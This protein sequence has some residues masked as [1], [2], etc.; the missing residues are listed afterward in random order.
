M[1][2][3]ND[4]EAVDLLLRKGFT[5]LETH[6]LILLRRTYRASELDEAPLD[7]ARLEFA[8]WLVMTGRLTDQIAE[9]KVS[10]APPPEK[11]PIPKTV[12]TGLKRH[13]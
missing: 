5:A 11:T 12:V 7:P 8:R 13:L 3:L 6:R 4:L 10:P 9:E 1:N 2:Q